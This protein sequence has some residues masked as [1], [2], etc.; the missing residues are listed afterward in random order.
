MTSL[1]RSSRVNPADSQPFL[2]AAEADVLTAAARA[3]RV[4]SVREASASDGRRS[5]ALHRSS[6]EPR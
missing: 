3:G 4:R 5:F 2:P 1:D 6:D